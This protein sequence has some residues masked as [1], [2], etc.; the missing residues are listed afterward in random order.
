MAARRPAS[1]QSLHSLSA[2][3]VPTLKRPATSS[4]GR[5]SARQAVVNN[6]SRAPLQD[7]SGN[8]NAAGSQGRNSHNEDAKKTAPIKARPALRTAASAAPTSRSAVSRNGSSTSLASER[9]IREENS[10]QSLRESQD[11]S[12]GN[13]KVVVR[14]R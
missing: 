9:Q 1:A 12:Q 7:A 6:N 3:A 11:S 4:T 10:T 13:I 2:P 14:C 8:A 5:P